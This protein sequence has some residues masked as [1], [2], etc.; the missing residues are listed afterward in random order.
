[1]KKVL[2]WFIIVVGTLIIFIVAFGFYTH[3]FRIPFT[4]GEGEKIEGSIGFFSGHACKPGLKAIGEAIYT[5]GEGPFSGCSY[6]LCDCYVC[7]KCGDGICGKGENY[8]NCKE[9]CKEGEG[10]YVESDEPKITSMGTI[11]NTLEI[12]G[13][14]KGNWFFEGQLPVK[15]LDG[16]G[17]LVS[18]G[19]AVTKQMTEDW[20][21]FD[22]SFPNTGTRSG[23][24][25]F[26]KDNPSGLPQNDKSVSVPFSF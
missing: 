15:L 26:S 24:L 1:M 20:V 21:S 5:T 16:K 25:I 11:G 12:G 2:R 22:A 10:V 7:T 19:T 14:I 17:N 9:D 8:C 4:V 13:K 18:K 3:I 23:T 6:P